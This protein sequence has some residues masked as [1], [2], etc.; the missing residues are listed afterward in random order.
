M[1]RACVLLALVLSPLM[2]AADVP[3]H[4]TNHQPDWLG[5]PAN[6]REMVPV[7]DFFPLGV[8]GGSY[9]EQTWNF[10]L[11]DLVQHHMNCWYL[12]GGGLDDDAL[13]RLLTKAEQAGVRIY[14]QDNGHPMY[15][16]WMIGTPESRKERHEKE[17]VPIVKQRAARFKGRW[18]LLAWG[19][20][21]EMPAWALDEMVDYYDLVRR[22]D[23]NHPPLLYFNDRD[24]AKKAVE[25]FKP[26]IVGAG[27]YPLGRDPRYCSDTVPRAR[28]LFRRF[29]RDYYDIAR[30]GDASLWFVTQGFGSAQAFIDEPPHNGWM[31]GYYMPNPTF[32]AWEAWAAIQEGARGV[33]YFH[34]YSGADHTDLTLR[35]ELWNETCQLKAI[36]TAFEQISKATPYLLHAEKPE[37]FVP[38]ASSETDVEVAPFQPLV[39]PEGLLIVV[40]VN[41]NTVNQRTFQL[42]HGQGEDARVWDL[43]TDEDITRANQ[44]SDVLI[45]AGM[46]KV[47]AVGSRR[48]IRAFK[49][50]CLPPK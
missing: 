33:F 13:D 2:A 24:V 42:L 47:L 50:A 32:C 12:N 18:G 23:P 29:C 43:V 22:E 46:G 30:S 20:C 1:C 5:P 27:C 48:A 39:G 11:D 49:A 31:G 19:L 34:Y 36:G 44:R 26:P 14:Y 41:N 10:L 45:K 3:D 9:G 21:E 4:V 7:K 16:P 6:E 37:R 35:T 28:D 25:M 15:Y 8:Y 38:V 17:I 40:A